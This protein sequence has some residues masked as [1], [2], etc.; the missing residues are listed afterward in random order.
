MDG[1]CSSNNTIY[2]YYGCF[3]HGHCGPNKDTKKWVKTKLREKYLASLGYNIVSITSC[4]WKK[5]PAS[6]EHFSVTQTPCTF[7]DVK[8]GIMN[9]ESFGFVKCDIHVPDDLIPRF[10]EFPP[11]FKNTEIPI[12]EIGEHMQAYCRSITREN[13]VERS[14]I[15]SM[16]GK[17]IVIMTPL[18]QKYIELGLVCTDIYWVIEY[19]PKKVFEWFVNDVTNTRRMADMDP[20]YKIRGETAKTKGNAAVGI[21]MI[22]RTRHTSVKYCEQNNVGRHI[23]NPLFKSLDE[24]NDDIYEV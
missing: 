15:S 4:E 7:L 11:I 17:G 13:G 8:E 14:L 12:S 18:F 20:S 23:Q 3:H 16:K 24:L 9:N 6:K 10:S 19:S 21:T 22:D 2:E 5:D 1:F